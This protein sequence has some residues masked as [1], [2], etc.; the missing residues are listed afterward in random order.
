[1][2]TLGKQSKTDVW[3]GNMALWWSVVVMFLLKMSAGQQVDHVLRQSTTCQKDIPSGDFGFYFDGDEMFYVDLDSKEVVYKLPEFEKVFSFEAQYGLQELAVCFF[4]LDIYIKRSRGISGPKVP[5]E[6][7]IYPSRPVEVGKPSTLICHAGGF[8]PTVLNVSWSKNGSPL[9]EGITTTDFYPEKIFAFQR[10]SYLNFIPDEGDIYSCTVEHPALDRPTT[11]FWQAEKPLLHENRTVS[12]SIHRKLKGIYLY[13]TIVDC[14][15]MN[16]GEIVLLIQTIIYN[17]ERQL[18]FDSRVGKFIGITENGKIDAEYFN[19]NTEYLD[20]LKAAV[21]TFCRYNYNLMKDVIVDR[22]GDSKGSFTVD[23]DMIDIRETSES[24]YDGQQSIEQSSGDHILRQSTTCQK[25]IPSGDFG[26][27]LD[28]DELFYVDLDTKEVVYRLPEIESVFSF[29]AQGGLQNLAVCRHNLDIY[30]KRTNSTSGPIV[31]PVVK[32]Y[33]MQHVKPGKPN[34]LIC[35]TEDFFPCVLNISWSKNGIPVKEGITVTDFYPGKEFTFKRFAY[36][37]FIPVQ[38]DIYSCN[39]EHPGLD[40]PTTVFWQP[41][42][43]SGNEN[44]TV[45][46]SNYYKSS[47]TY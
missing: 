47:G 6:V 31:P 4:N 11:V 13:Q 7:K 26:F 2:N 35:A 17:K 40:R 19:N 20:N 44:K 27:Y 22:K 23:I 1:M 46:F 18:F 43:P 29:E 33:P 37:T 3:N 39:V 42:N 10:F 21:T 8:F 14:L 24:G 16:D 28:D 30:I 9:E 34:T 38:G 36:L 25:D 5:P 32:V 45:S 41:D 15:Y 12:L